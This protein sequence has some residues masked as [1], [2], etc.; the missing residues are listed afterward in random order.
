MI[1]EKKMKRN[2]YIYNSLYEIT[3]DKI[4][5]KQQI[6][7]QEKILRADFENF[8]DKFHALNIVLKLFNNTMSFRNLFSIKKRNLPNWKMS[9]IIAYFTIGYKFISWIISNIKK[10]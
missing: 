5:L 4:L 3:I 7:N 9:E 8:K 6:Y 1:E 2:N 10:K